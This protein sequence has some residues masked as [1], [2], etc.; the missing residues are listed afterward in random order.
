MILSSIWVHLLRSLTQSNHTLP[1]EI[2]AANRPGVTTTVVLY[3]FIT[4]HLCKL[5]PPPF[6]FLP[7]CHRVLPEAAAHAEFAFTP[8]CLS[9]P[10]SLFFSPLPFD[11]FIL[12]LFFWPSQLP[13]SIAQP[14]HHHHHPP[15]FSPYLP[16]PLPDSCFYN[17]NHTVLSSLG[18][19]SRNRRLSIT[20]KIWRLT[21][22]LRRWSLQ[23]MHTHN[24][25][26]YLY[27]SDWLV[28]VQPAQIKAHDVT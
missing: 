16:L 5:P 15:L 26:P 11:L 2:T 10:P 14:H 25:R 9:L 20:E 13:P 24:N 6:I 21:A 23:I 3:L 22:V 28:F 8:P 19:V 17:L 27:L 1:G 4:T 18:R 7:V 12:R